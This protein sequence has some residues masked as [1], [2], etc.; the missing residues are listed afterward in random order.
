MFC[1]DPAAAAVGEWGTVTIKT[2]FKVD[3]NPPH[4]HLRAPTVASL[5]NLIS[6][7]RSGVMEAGR[8][9]WRSIPREIEKKIE[10][11]LYSI[12]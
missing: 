4:S 2:P 1:L 9:T 7:L 12:K 8:R 6:W 3:L 10:N 11:L 5:I